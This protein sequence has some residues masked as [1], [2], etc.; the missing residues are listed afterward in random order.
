MHYSVLLAGF[1]LFAGCTPPQISR[2]HPV[3]EPRISDLQ[4]YPQNATA[5]AQNII[6]RNL[7]VDIQKTYRSHYFLPWNMTEPPETLEAVMWPFKIYK[8]EGSYGENL[9]LLPQS[10][11]D[12]M[13]EQANFDAYG[14]LNR[15]AITLRFS[16]L[17]N[18]PTGKPLFRDPKQAGE[19]FPFD[20]LQN[21]GIHANEP[22]FV[23]HYSRD[24]AWVYVF[25]AYATGW[26]PSHSIAYMTEKET[27]SW[28][29]AKQLHL[30]S[31]GYPIKDDEGRFLFYGRLGMMLP[32]IDVEENYYH[33]RT[34]AA[35]VDNTPTFTE[36]EIP[37]YAGREEVM[38]LNRQTLP[39]L[40]NEVMQSNYGW[41]GMYT[42]RDCSSTLRD[43]Y[44][45]FGI[46]LPRNSFQQANT[47]RVFSLKGMGRTQKLAFIKE[48][49]IPF[50]TLLYRKGHILLYL[51]VYEGE[52]MVLHNMWGIRTK[53]G[54]LEG[55]LIV[56]K[57]V[58]STLDIGSDQSDYDEE[59]N[60]L[61]KLESMNIITAEEQAITQ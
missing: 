25:T 58:I 29:E 51:G 33:V 4:H 56:G 54:D 34:V 3:E 28:Q 6:D 5:Y 35:G 57:T 27:Q 60:M 17:R 55:R 40:A 53:T 16:H 2:L 22:L 23:S 32:L 45:P 31:E 13:L 30:V 24:G 11:F 39:Q 14:T 15:R 9:K 59:N 10:W 48:K 18:F 38:L 47:G 21:S 61:E 46:W 19:G 44:A 50:E 42:E 26:L 52:V 37:K 8:A 20:Y 41:G 43:M 1:L 36:A 12:A 7:L 49:G